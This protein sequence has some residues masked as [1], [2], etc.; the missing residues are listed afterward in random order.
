MLDFVVMAD[1]GSGSAKREREKRRI[2]RRTNKKPQSRALN[3]K[4]ATRTA[5]VTRTAAPW[6]P[7]CGTSGYF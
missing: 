5:E 1:T 6:A 2:D 7:Q 3:Q 4:L